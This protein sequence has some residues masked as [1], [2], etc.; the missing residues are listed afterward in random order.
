MGHEADGVGEH[1]D[2]QSVLWSPGGEKEDEAEERGH[3]EER[4]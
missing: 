3:R 1:P 4:N 2:H